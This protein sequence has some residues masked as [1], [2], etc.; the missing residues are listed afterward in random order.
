VRP[1]VS[2]LKRP[3]LWQQQPQNW[4]SRDVAV[5]GLA[6][7]GGGRIWICQKRPGV[8]MITDHGAFGGRGSPMI[9]EIA[10]ASRD[11][12]EMMTETC[13]MRALAMSRL[14]A[15]SLL[16]ALVPPTRFGLAS[17]VV[18]CCLGGVFVWPVVAG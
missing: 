17:V 18:G 1:P 6:Y 14:G 11:N 5:R 2:T 4:S 9:L 13:R 8:P 7:A 12:S 10:P 15:A 16:S 3:R